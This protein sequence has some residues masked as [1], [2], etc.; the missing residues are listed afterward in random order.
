METDNAGFE[1]IV[2]PVIAAEFFGE[3]LFPS[4]AWFW[5]GWIGIL[6]AQ[7][8]Y[9]GAG[10]LITGVN[11]GRRGEKELVYAIQAA[12]FKHVSVDKDIVSR[13]VGMRSGDVA[14]TAHVG[15][16]IVNLPDSTAGGM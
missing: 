1:L 14:D 7:R 10:L 5:I 15:R 6:F 11:A 9:V 8:A 4:V 2:A 13:N 12:G 16:Q 3:K